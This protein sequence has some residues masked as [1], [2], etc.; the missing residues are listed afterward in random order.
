MLP[1]TSLS[2]HIPFLTS[3]LCLLSFY[4]SNP[5]CSV[6]LSFPFCHLFSSSLPFLIPLPLFLLLSF[7]VPSLAF[8]FFSPFLLHF[9]LFFSPVICLLSFPVFLSLLLFLPSCNF[10]S[11][12][13]SLLSFPYP[14][15][16]SAL[17]CSPVLCWLNW[18][19]RQTCVSGPHLPR[20]SLLP[21][22]ATLT[23]PPPSS[24][25]PFSFTSSH[26][27]LHQL[28]FTSSMCLSLP[29][30]VHNNSLS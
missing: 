14:L 2:P 22:L 28:S 19:C 30:T 1:L 11:F 26:L 18:I 15:L 3:L 16:C 10:F 17:L 13:S 8:L 24:L 27:S 4:A 29:L 6:Y 20:A 21:T 7:L 23:H 25:Y 9:F 5:I 12:L